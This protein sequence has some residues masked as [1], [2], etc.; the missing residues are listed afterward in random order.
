MTTL[1]ER[2]LF[3]EKECKGGQD[4][5]YIH[6][7]IKDI[8]ITEPT[9]PPATVD[10][11]DRAVWAKEYE[12]YREKKCILEEL[13]PM[14]YALL[15]GQCSPGVMTKLEGQEK[16]AGDKANRD[17]VGLLKLIQGICCNFEAKTKPYWALTGA[18]TR[19]AL[20]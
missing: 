5:G 3:V 16:Y 4:I 11:C 20:F 7:E 9:K 18:K 17:L 15:L 14:T 8:K 10:R 13:K 1:K 2:A 6:H 19:F 12:K